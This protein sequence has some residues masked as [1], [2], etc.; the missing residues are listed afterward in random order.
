MPRSDSREAS[1]PGLHRPLPERPYLGVPD[2]S[3]LREY[4]LERDEQC[5]VRDDTSMP[6]KIVVRDEV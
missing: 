3:L 4:V 1:A 2:L 6:P 5:R